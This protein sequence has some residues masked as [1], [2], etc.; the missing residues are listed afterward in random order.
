MAEFYSDL[1]KSIRTG[2]LDSHEESTVQYQPDFILNDRQKN[3][4]VLSY[5][6]Q[7]LEVCDRFWLSGAFLTTSGLACL[8]NS[9]K[10]FG[11]SGKGEGKIFISDYFVCNLIC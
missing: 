9:L 7:R 4:K 5:I 10:S 3:T 11:M 1:E 6:L 2:F 8:H